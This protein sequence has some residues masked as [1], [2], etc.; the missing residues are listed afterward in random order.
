MSFSGTP[1]LREKMRENVR[2]KPRSLTV[3]YGDRATVHVRSRRDV[4]HMEGRRNM[5]E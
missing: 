2:D 4:K 1:V 3:L 5:Y